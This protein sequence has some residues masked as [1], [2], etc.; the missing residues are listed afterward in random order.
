MILG[1]WGLNFLVL[2][3]LLLIYISWNTTLQPVEPNRSLVEV[4]TSEEPVQ[5]VLSEA[6]IMNMNGCRLEAKARFKV[7]ARI[8]GIHHYWNG[9]EAK[10]SPLDLALGWGVMSDQEV[11]KRIRIAQGGRWYRWSVS[12]WHVSR[13][14]I[15]T[16]S[17]NMH[18]IPA[19][20]TI[21][22]ELKAL[23]VGEVVELSGYLVNVYDGSWRW[24]TSL[25]RNDVGQ[26]SCEV[27]Y[28]EKLSRSF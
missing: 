20:S 16:H 21:K 8:L 1:K 22:S 4:A 13:S 26:G 14:D 7:T 2:I 18:I 9:H 6:V 24:L 10:V 11:L 23:R 28:V 17:A 27:F 5:V 12:S 25:T 15:E 3:A 19:D